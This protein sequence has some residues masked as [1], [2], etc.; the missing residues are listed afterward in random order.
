MLELNIRAT[1]DADREFVRAAMVQ[2]WLSSVIWSRGVMYTDAHTLP[3]FVA[4]AHDQRVGHVTTAFE[5]HGAPTGQCEVV[6]L[7]TGVENRGV[8]ARLLAAAVHAARQRGCAR[9]FLTT[10]NDN[11]R[12]LGFYQK[13]GWRIVRAWPG[14]IDAARALEPSIPVVG[15][16][17]IPLHDEIE[18]ELRLDG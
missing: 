15:M 10:A 7:A 6:T 18:L 13:R 2:H 14:M 9:V 12:A 8:G 1:T 5:P 4:E 17:G 16:H 3:G 11:L